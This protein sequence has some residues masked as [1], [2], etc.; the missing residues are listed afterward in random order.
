M[1]YNIP[2]RN[3]IGLEHSAYWDGFLN[4]E[5]LNYLIYHQNWKNLES[6][7]IGEGDG[8]LDE[9]RRRTD[10][11]WL[12]LDQENIKLWE[13]LSN[14][15]AEV[16]RRFFQFDLSGFYEPMQLGLYKSGDKGHYDWHTDNSVMESKTPRKLSMSISLSDP[17]DYQGGE[18]QIKPFSDESITLENRKGRA[19]FFP[20]YTL[21]RVTPVTL[22]LRKSAVLWIGGPQFR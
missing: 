11:C 22:G 19:W 10:I 4:E 1:I 15:A 16:N 14:V 7:Q 2:P 17:N 12:G 13:K 21:H 6:A 8:I 5:E 3:N 20:S 18:L 9:K